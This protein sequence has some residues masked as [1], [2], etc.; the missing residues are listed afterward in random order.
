M[1]HS[2]EVPYT[3]IAAIRILRLEIVEVE[4]AAG[5]WASEA[6]VITRPPASRSKQ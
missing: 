4:P 1:L 3:R 5:S 2:F 6:V